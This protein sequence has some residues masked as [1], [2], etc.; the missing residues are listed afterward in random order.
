MRQ[1]LR[2]EKILRPWLG[3][4]ICSVLFMGAVYLHLR[5]EGGLKGL[6][7]GVSSPTPGVSFY[8]YGKEVLLGEDPNE[9]KLNTDVDFGS[10]LSK[11]LVSHKSPSVDLEVL[12]VKVIPSANNNHLDT[13]SA[14]PITV[15]TSRKS[16]K[17]CSLPASIYGEYEAREEELRELEIEIEKQKR[18]V[19]AKVRY[20]EKVREQLTFLLKKGV[21][22]N[23][24]RI[25]KLVNFYSSMRPQSAAQ[26][27]NG[28]DEDLAVDILAKMRK[29]QA[30]A[31]MNRL[32]PQKVQKLSEKFVGY[33]QP[34]V[35]YLKKK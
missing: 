9:E 32:E 11:E 23:E 3:L 22:R 8:S 28:I 20:L 17:P 4:F 24:A 7:G 33:R 6:W 10:G 34:S 1:L 26:I 13:V 16:S 25:K 12:G 31:I 30:A 15:L 35:S 5:Q 27:I 2:G 29:L 21:D 19:D 18:E 14:A